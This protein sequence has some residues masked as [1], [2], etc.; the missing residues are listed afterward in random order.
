MKISTFT[1]EGLNF[2][3][4]S[5][6]SDLKVVFCDLG[7]SI[8]NIYFHNELMTRNVNYFKDFKNPACYY[9][10]TIGRTSNRL[11]GYRF[12]IHNVIYNLEPNEG[13]NV[14][15]GGRNGL[16]NKVFKAQ[17]DTFNDYVEVEFTYLSKHL[18]AGY[19]GN[20]NIVVKYIVY[21]DE[22]KLDVIYSALSDMDT[23]FS[24]T[25][26]SYF[27]LG[28]ND[29][30]N[31]DLYIKGHKYL[32]VDKSCLLAKDIRP[33]NDVMDF[34]K[35]K[36]ISKDI[37]SNYLK[38]KMMNGYD[39]FWYFDDVNKNR[40]NVS[41]RNNR[42][43]MDVYTDFEGTQIYSSNYEAPFALQGGLNFRDSVAIEPSD[44]FYK[45]PVLL[46]DH[47]YSREIRYIFKTI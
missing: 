37:D 45:L 34:T 44:S 14:L 7:A 46:K 40:I 6:D 21:K 35:Y 11:K 22:N 18:E 29:I 20:V 2:I 25:N 3:E 39:S 30:S 4:V 33:I 17:V 8:F 10:K 41:L 27:T 5:N 38:G 32:N 42:Y 24:L 12:D 1:K 16:S 36:K 47:L 31:L 19:P 15:H 26:H 28:D 23:L 13:P 43:Q 9:G